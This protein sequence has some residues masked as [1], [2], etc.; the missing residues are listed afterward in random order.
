[1]VSLS[2]LRLAPRPV[3]AASRRTLRVL[4]TAGRGAGSNGDPAFLPAEQ[5][6]QFLA[7]ARAQ[8]Q[9]STA[10]E[11]MQAAAAGPS[12][13]AAAAAAGSTRRAALRSLLL[14]GAA[15]FAL[16]A[17]AAF[18]RPAAAFKGPA[19]LFGGGAPAPAAAA[20][21]A[22]PASMENKVGLS[23]LSRLSCAG[24]GGLAGWPMQ[25]QQACSV[26][27][28]RDTSVLGCCRN[29]GRP[30]SLW[31]L[32]SLD[33]LLTTHPP[34][35]QTPLPDLSELSADEVLTIKLFKENT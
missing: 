31:A 20:V 30:R 7:A 27:A 19:G 18:P 5:R 10:T 23:R 34:P 13:A 21:D 11:S 28:G 33:H 14:S 32:P 3:T 4:A 6:R 12:A 35:L 24:S 1:M 16:L 9:C 8:Q 22:M 29:R 17:A 15:A 25:P 26:G 2:R